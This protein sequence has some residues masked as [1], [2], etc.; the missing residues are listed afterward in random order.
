MPMLNKTGLTRLFFETAL[1]AAL[2]RLGVS[3]VYHMTSTLANPLDCEIW[4]RA[5]R[6]K[7]HPTPETKALTRSEWDGILGHCQAV[8]DYPAS[9]FIPELM[10]IYPETKIILSTRD[11]DKWFVSMMT[12]IWPAINDPVMD[13]IAPLDG[14]LL[15]KWWPMV[16]ACI[17]W[18]YDGEFLVN[19]KKVF[20][21]S[22]EEVRRLVPKERLLEFEVTMGWEPLCRFLD[23]DVPDEPFP[24]L[25]DQQQ[26]EKLMG[27]LAPKAM[28]RIAIK[29]IPIAG[30][31]I[32]VALSFWYRRRYV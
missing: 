23:V 13:A 14:R 24:R 19:A 4:M 5:L 2:R 16:Q 26:F 10:E 15:A 18:P 1:S 30:G 7:Y 25:N 21:E 22:H 3:E 8:I 20:F 31:I 6:H 28:M 9:L 11:V 32:A 27:T 29:T 17:K 12:T